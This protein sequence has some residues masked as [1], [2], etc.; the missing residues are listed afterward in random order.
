MNEKSLRAKA[1]AELLHKPATEAA[2]RQALR[3]DPFM[4]A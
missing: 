3:N 2:A 4:A 1:E